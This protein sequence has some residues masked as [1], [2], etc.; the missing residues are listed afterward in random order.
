MKTVTTIIIISYQGLLSVRLCTCRK[1]YDHKIH[2]KLSAKISLGRGFS[3]GYSQ[4][5]SVRSSSCNYK[6][7]EYI[8]IIICSELQYYITRGAHMYSETSN[9]GLSEKRT[10]SVQQTNP[11]PPIE[12][13]I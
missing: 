4:S 5:L 1:N 7:W 11:V 6:L 13:T 3:L 8:N 10:T 2:G 12:P 9:N